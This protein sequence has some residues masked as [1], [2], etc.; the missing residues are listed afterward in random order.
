MKKKPQVPQQAYIKYLKDF[1][2]TLMRQEAWMAGLETSPNY[3]SILDSRLIHEDLL[4][5]GS[6]SEAR[7]GPKNKAKPE[8][9]YSFLTRFLKRF[10][11]AHS[12]LFKIQAEEILGEVGANPQRLLRVVATLQQASMGGSKKKK[13]SRSFV[14]NTSPSK[15]CFIEPN[16][17]PRSGAQSGAGGGDGAFEKVFSLL[18]LALML[19]LRSQL[20]LKNLW[21]F[22]EQ[23][24][25][26]RLKRALEMS[27]SSSTEAEVAE[28]AAGLKKQISDFE[29][30]LN[31]FADLEPP[32]SPQIGIP[33]GK[34]VRES[35][36]S[37]VKRTSVASVAESPQKA[38]KLL[39][40]QKET[41]IGKRR[42]QASEAVD[43]KE[44]ILK[45]KL[46][47][48]ISRARKGLSSKRKISKRAKSKS[49]EIAIMEPRYSEDPQLGP[50]LSPS[51]K[52]RPK[53]S[54][55][56]QKKISKNREK[57]EHNLL[58]L[59]TL[60][61]QTA[62][63]TS[64]WMQAL[65]YVQNF[66]EYVTHFI[67]I[68]PKI[69]R[70]KNLI[71][72]H[73][74]LLKGILEILYK[75]LKNREKIYHSEAQMCLGAAQI[76][77]IQHKPRSRYWMNFERFHK[78]MKQA[79]LQDVK[80][81]KDGAAVR[82]SGGNGNGPKKSNTK[83]GNLKSV[84]AQKEIGL[85]IQSF[86]LEISN[87]VRSNLS[88][89]VGEPVRPRIQLRGSVER[90]GAA[91]PKPQ[92]SPKSGQNGIIVKAKAVS[93]ALGG[94]AKQLM[95]KKKLAQVFVL[96][97]KLNFEINQVSKDERSYFQGELDW[98][99]GDELWSQ[100]PLLLQELRAWEE[101]L[102]SVD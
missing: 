74:G 71:K 100:T 20:I 81:E 101:G 31:N 33:A 14:Q 63:T 36:R 57:L 102:K 79:M 91:E 19:F 3:I 32:K 65:L 45:S 29:K 62:P 55:K 85:Q 10:S 83:T 54:K 60:L 15:H 42:K 13:E 80:K 41:Q 8:F 11:S 22:Q 30:N 64:K 39:L 99:L 28:L 40:K 84:V 56:S 38:K 72:T 73:P 37:F 7:R 51:H 35:T 50:Q 5:A 27:A 43:R 87:Y 66:T 16:V 26:K 49:P 97:F 94:L 61:S 76:L 53:K 1:E 34:A 58:N 70:R 95:L 78:E 2:M 68:L 75:L 18:K 24:L 47:R 90:N 48:A 6:P 44:K 12:E 96:C 98:I 21:S 77:P 4:T 17:V 69:I 86:L 89:I 25:E 82:S 67:E 23:G 52:K 46:R 59:T 9:R 93:E 88:T 92:N